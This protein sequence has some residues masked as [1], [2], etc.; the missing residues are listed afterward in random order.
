[1]T[2]PYGYICATN[3]EWTLGDF[4]LLFAH[5][6]RHDFKKS[7]NPSDGLLTVVGDQYWVH[8]MFPLRDDQMFHY[9]VY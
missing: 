6:W 9:S 3:K 8:R 4:G 7:G 5:G 2:A 1:M